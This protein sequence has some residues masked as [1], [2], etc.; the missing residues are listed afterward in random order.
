MELSPNEIDWWCNHTTQQITEKYGIGT[1][2]VARTKKKYS[3]KTIRMP[4]SGSRTKTTG[5]Y[6]K[7]KNSSCDETVWVI[8]SQPEKYCS[9]DCTYTCAEYRDKLSSIDKS[10]M[11]TETYSISKQKED[12][13]EYRRYANKVHKLSDKVYNENI[14]TINPDRHPRT[15]AGVEGGWQLD[16]I[17]EV[18]FGFDNGIPFVILC[19]PSNLRMLPWK[20]NIARNKKDPTLIV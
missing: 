1:A 16:H 5:S 13:S 19:D 7:C 10:Y 11:Q 20:E 12:V 14:D 17:I 6:A 4:G 18:R 15:L 8:P 2:T 9:R 3:I